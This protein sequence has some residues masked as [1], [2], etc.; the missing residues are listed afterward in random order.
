MRP[1]FRLLP[2]LLLALNPLALRADEGMWTF[3]NLPLG[4]LKAKYGFEPSAAWLKRL[5]LVGIN[6]D[7][8]YEGQGG[9]YV[10]DDVTQRAVATDARAILEGLRK[11]MD[12]GWVADGLTAR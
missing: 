11:V 1:S 10:Y 6:F 4:T 5:Q 9:Y 2:V 12:A 3:D 8:V 7:S